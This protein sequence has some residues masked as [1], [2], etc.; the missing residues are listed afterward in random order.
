MDL[1]I[2]HNPRC[3]KSRQTLALLDER[4]LTPKIRL[5]LQD[6]P[7]RPRFAQPSKPS[8]SRPK[9]PSAAAKPP[10]K[11]SLSPPPTRPP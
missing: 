11:T 9:S 8:A 2:W 3:T 5:Y 10:T 1:T 6:Q 7:T 4:G